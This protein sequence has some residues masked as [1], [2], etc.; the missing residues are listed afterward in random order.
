ML[1]SSGEVKDK[2]YDDL[3]TAIKRIDVKEPLFILGDSM[4]ERVSIIVPGL[5]MKES[6]QWEN[7]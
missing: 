5:S 6:S 2:F 3:S 1:T 4:P 7:E